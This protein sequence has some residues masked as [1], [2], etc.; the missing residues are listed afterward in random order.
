MFAYA[1]QDLAQQR[2][3]VLEHGIEL[4]LRQRRLGEQVLHE[5]DVAAQI[6]GE[7]EERGDEVQRDGLVG[8][9]RESLR[10]L[11]QPGVAGPV[12]GVRPRVAGQVRD[13]SRLAQGMS[14]EVVVEEVAVGPDGGLAADA[15]LILVG[16]V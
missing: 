1:V 12:M 3:L 13:A 10:G 11:G 16:V 14:H 15:E 9:S 5:A 2:R 8:A 4:R 7:L 6:P